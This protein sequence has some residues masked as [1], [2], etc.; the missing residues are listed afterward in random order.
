[1]TPAT[2]ELFSCFFS[3]LYILSL[4][5]LF[6]YGTN[7]YVLLLLFWRHRGKGE[8]E[9][10]DALRRFE[11][12]R[13][14][15]EPPRVTIQLPVYN[16][17][18]VVAR[19]IEA[20]AALDYPRDRIEIQ[21][22]DDST[23]ETA[24][25]VG[26]LVANYRKLGIPIAHLRRPNRNGFKA[27][28]LREGMAQASGEL[29]AI[30]DADFVPPPDFLRRTIP[31][32]L[33][34]KVGM[35]QARWAH[36]NADE[37]LLTR[38][39][40]IGIDAHFSVEQG[41]RAWSGLFL[42]FNGTA[43]IW[44]RQAILDAGGWQAD[45]LTEDM[46]LSYRAQLAGWQLKYVFEVA[47]PAE[48]P[49]EVAAFKSQ[50]FRWAKGS[51]QTA[52]K[53]IPRLLKSRRSWFAKY[54]AVLHMTHYIVH[55]LM[56]VTIVLSYPVVVLSG[57]KSGPWLLA[58]AFV[59]FLLATLGPSVLYIASQRSLYKDWR[60]RV[61]WVSLMTLIGTGIALNNTRAVLEG[62]FLS[63]GRFVRTPKFGTSQ[64]G[65]RREAGEYRLRVD[66]LPCLE[67]ALGAYALV[68]FTKAIGSPGIFISPFLLMYTCGFLYMGF[69]GVGEW[70]DR[71]D[72][73][74]RGV[75]YLRVVRAL[76]GEKLAARM[77]RP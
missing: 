62:L 26:R 59:L 13:W 1:M 69:R 27:G 73:L 58:A 4:S 32:F 23:D 36:L 40:S 52:R 21:V 51:I 37:S 55:P 10:R 7:C 9:Y 22:L 38:A 34:P 11:K 42:N 24:E 46:D 54:Q 18:Y 19:L 41:A 30:F 53:T 12:S 61:R 64:Q 70:L 57:Y 3:A 66:L 71:N 72:E 15:A 28:A 25:I 2:L 39:Q 50:Q 43:G 56:L 49:S 45:T 31:C 60:S 68:A 48:L 33:D 77:E 14:S 76:R 65:D 75:R 20:V 17:R 5:G 63:G 44:R 47:C 8:K 35:V 16:E 74:V 6:L 29:F 67:L